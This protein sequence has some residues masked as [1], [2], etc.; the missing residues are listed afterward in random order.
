MSLITGIF[1]AKERPLV[2]RLLERMNRAGVLLRNDR[3]AFHLAGG[4]GLGV[5]QFHDDGSPLQPEANPQGTRRIVLDGRIDNRDEIARLLDLPRER[6]SDAAVVLAAYDA[7]GPEGVSRLLGDFAW[8]LWDGVARRLVAARDVLG[9]RPLFYL[10][11]SGLVALASQI[12]QLLATAR[13]S[14]DDLDPAFIADYFVAGKSVPEATP[15]RQIRSVPPAH[16]LIADEGGS[17]LHRYWDLEDRPKLVYRDPREYPEH[18][19]S[20]FKEAVRVQCRSAGGPVWCDLSGGL[21]SSSIACVAAQELEGLEAS[22]RLATLSVVFDRAKGS[23]ERRWAQTVIDQY[24]LENHQISGD[25]DFSLETLTSGLR[26]WDL[27]CLEAFLSYGVH[28]RIVSR[29]RRRGVEALLK[30]LGAESVIL[31]EAVP[32]LHLADLLRSG[33][34]RRCFSELLRWQEHLREPLLTVLGRHGLRPLLMPRTLTVPTYGG[35]PAWVDPEFA[36][37]MKI[38]SR[39]GRAWFPRR[40]RSATD[41]WQYEQLRRLTSSL[42]P[43]CLHKV[44]DVR[45]PFLYRPLVEFAMRVPWDHKVELGTNKPLLRRAMRGILPEAIR[46]RR[47]LVSGN[48]AVHQAL[49][50]QWPAINQ[51]IDSSRLAAMGFVN[52]RA[53]RCEAALARQGATHFLAGLLRPLA[54]EAWL[55]ARLEAESAHPVSNKQLTAA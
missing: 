16:L 43:G 49:R 28:C 37:R 47:Q 51:F 36:R 17:R 27:P 54:L 20:L 7:W 46:T 18:F 1:C 41:Q 35:P 23:D 44:C 42:H 40:F 52:R 39:S 31:G 29:L 55:R 13:V 33:R 12:D 2:A 48:P 26:F 4:A 8:V 21:D 22:G 3:G 15:Y 24:D 53:L 9:L 45:M 25:D 32:P 19:A 11:D 6:R 50:K 34:V 38:T 10:E 14:I 5:R 30:G